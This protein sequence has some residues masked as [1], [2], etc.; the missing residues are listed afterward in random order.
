M[1]LHR[2]V[3]FPVHDGSDFSPAWA[4]DGNSLAFSSSRT[5]DPEIWI[6]SAAGFNLRR[7]TAYRGPDVSPVWNP[8]TGTQIAWISGRTGLPQVY[9][10]DS[11]GTGVQRMTDGG[12]A[13]SPSWS[14][15]GQ[16][17]AFAW[18][19]HYGPGAPGGQDIYVMDIASHRWIQLTHTSGARI[20]PPGHR[21]AATSSSRLGIVGIAI[22]GPC[23]RTAPGSMP[24]PNLAVIECLTGAGSNQVFRKIVLAKDLVVLHY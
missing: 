5:G 6:S 1:T 3:S 18:S 9:I 7:V 23:W 4:P 12:Y 20:F 10:M 15:N 2:M 19:R 8:K 13:T 16:F 21:T 11:D 17:L 14:P 24:S 22:Y